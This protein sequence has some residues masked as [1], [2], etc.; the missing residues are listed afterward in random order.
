MLR[1]DNAPVDD[2]GPVAALTRLRE[3]S[4]A[5]TR[6]TDLAALHRLDELTGL[7]LDDTAVS[8]D[9]VDALRA[10]RPGLHIVGAA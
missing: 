9:Q 7:D 1:L 5:G 8:A 10:A 4:L 2:V 3:L 6:V